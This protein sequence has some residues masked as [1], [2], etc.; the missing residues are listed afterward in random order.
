LKGQYR[1]TLSLDPATGS[2]NSAKNVQALTED[3]WFSQSDGGNGSSVEPY[4]ASTEFNGQIEDLKMFRQAVMDALQFPNNRWSSEENPATY[5][6]AVETDLQEIE[7]QK[8]CRRLGNKF[9]RGLIL[10][11]FIEHIRLRGL[12]T[13]FLNKDIYNVQ[14]NYATDFEKIRTLGMAGKIGEQVTTF[15]DFLPNLTNSK[16]T[17]EEG[18]PVFSK[19][20]FLHKILGMSDEDII[21]N[22]SLLKKEKEEILDAAKASADEGGDIDTSNEDF[23]F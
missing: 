15:K 16:A 21:E 3:Y 12:N 22:E 18:G 8:Q 19:Y 4:K 6:Q 7:F 11:T 2:I 20:F 9:V 1:K 5:S 13:K 10:H 17:S 14:F 23:A